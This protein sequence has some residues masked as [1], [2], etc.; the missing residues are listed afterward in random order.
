MQQELEATFTNVDYA[1]L[2]Q[3]L[4]ELQA[5]QVHPEFVMRR[6]VYDYPDLALDNK[7]AWARV[8]QEYDKVTMS[9]KQRQSQDINGMIEVELTVDNYDTACAFLEA[10]GLTPKAKQ[11]TRRETWTLDGCMVTLD[12]WPWIP[13]FVEIEGPSEAAVQGVA[14]AL[15]FDWSKAVFDSADGVYLQHFKATRTELATMNIQFGPVPEWLE[16]RRLPA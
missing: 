3:R 16:A 8:R 4:A 12:Q 10:I 7:A 11:E 5:T 2:R 15:D 14:A 9:Y 6:T 1:P 13:P